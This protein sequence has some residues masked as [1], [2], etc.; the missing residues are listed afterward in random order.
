[1]N[2]LYTMQELSK[3]LDV[4]MNTIREWHRKGD[5]E[6]THTAGEWATGNIRMYLFDLENVMASKV[7]GNYVSHKEVHKKKGVHK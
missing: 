4:A 1:M 2:R 3:K 6:P 7:W 5:I